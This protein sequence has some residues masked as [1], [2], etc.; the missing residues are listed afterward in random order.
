M[1]AFLSTWDTNETRS[2]LDAT[3][4]DSIF[5]PI[6]YRASMAEAEA[7]RILGETENPYMVIRDLRT[8]GLQYELAEALE[9]FVNS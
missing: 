5:F 4:H 6:A 2:K 3:G 8:Q 9:A 1:K 7:Q